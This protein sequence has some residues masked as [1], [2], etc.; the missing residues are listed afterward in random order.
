[1]LE[2]AVAIVGA[3]PTGMMLAAELRLAGVDVQ[4]LER[5]PDAQLTGSRAGGLQ[6]RTIEVF[7]QR[8]IAE[9]F[10]AEGTPAQVQGYGGV[11]LDISDFSTRYP[12]GLALWQ[13]RIEAILAEWV[14]ELGVTTRYGSDVVE[15]TQ[16][17]DGVIV[18]LADGH[19]I[20]A[21]YVVGC[22][23]G[24]SL[25]RKA[26]GIE[27]AGW[28][29]TVS[30]LIAEVEYRDEPEWGLRQDAQGVH[31]ITRL[32]AGG[33]S[34]ATGRPDG[35][36]GGRSGGDRS[37]GGRSGGDRSAGGRSG[38]DSSAVGGAWESS[39]ASRD[40][41]RIVLTERTL[42]QGSDP[43]L[44]DLSSAMR[45][46]WGSDFGV[47][48][49]TWISRFTDAARQATTYRSGR[50]LLAGDAA[51]VHYPAGGQGLSIGVQDAVNLGWKLA[52]VVSGVSPDALLDTY[53]SERH[54][55]AARVLQD[56]LAQ[57][58]LRRTDPRSRAVVAAVTE[59]L[60]F[61]AA[62][63]SFAGR[64][65]GLGVHYDLAPSG[66]DSDVHP[67]VGRRMP[68]LDLVVDGRPA[69]AFT[70][71]RDARPLYLGFDAPVEWTAMAAAAPRVRALQ[72]S[73]TGHWMLP[74]LGEV[75]PPRAVLVRPDG[76]VAW[77]AASEPA[78][79]QPAT[80]GPAVPGP[81]APEPDVPE[82]AVP[83]SAAGTVPPS[84]ASLRAALREWFGG[85]AS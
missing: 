23:G 35:S 3:G 71:L 20:H 73:T 53:E 25:V 16:N 41:V 68:D 69:R 75:P 56:T 45:E 28:D 2:C 5:R 31:G 12:Y 14:A 11:V 52:Q 27:F 83:G 67:L 61:D 62:R 46:I 22:D 64:L 78:A 21:Q 4:L 81:G 48:S 76:Y 72:G 32:A 29:A 26:A 51:H 85:M 44:A 1:M 33:G 39:A 9:R 10:L 17:D 60:G 63:R 13:N 54:P 55:I 7:D 82:P 59:L 47:H 15:V 74:D 40:T 19:P 38:G 30:N 6:S 58:A 66:S 57:V 8:G 65:S 18:R 84:T 50:L 77:A 49:P 43:T 24:R 79:S 42:Q 70:L 80:F 34:G 36:A 37:A